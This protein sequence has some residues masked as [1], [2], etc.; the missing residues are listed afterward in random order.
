ML[1]VVQGSIEIHDESPFRI[2]L[3]FRS[4]TFRYT[5]GWFEKTKSTPATISARWYT[6]S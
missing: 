2:E 1:C 6:M 4:L 3:Q 5:N